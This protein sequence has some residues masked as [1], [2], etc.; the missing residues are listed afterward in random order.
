MSRRGAPGREYLA[1]QIMLSQKLLASLAERSVEYPRLEELQHWQRARLR[2]TYQDLRRQQRF[3]AACVFFLEQLYGGRDMRERDRQLER[4]LPLMSKML[5][6][7]ILHAV[8]EAMRLQWMS[9]DFDARLSQML[10]G[11]LDQAEY[12][13]GYR[14]MGEWQGRQEQIRL[15]GQLGRLLQRMVRRKIIRRLVHWMYGPAHA[16]GFGKM[17]QFLAEGFD[18]FDEMGDQA[19]YFVETIE[20]REML[21]LEWM[22]QGSDRPFAEWIGD[23]PDA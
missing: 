4:I 7:E 5:A 14:R 11:E 12:A 17:Q 10:E 18:S 9:M 2:E 1:E 13:R 19:E 6:D 16:A 8:G 15:I 21:A 23:G 22:E 20:M 3:R